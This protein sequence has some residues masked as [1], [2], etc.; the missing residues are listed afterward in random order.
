MPDIT[1]IGI[2]SLKELFLHLKKELVIAPA[3]SEP[4]ESAPSHLKTKHPNLDDVIGQEQAKRALVI[5]AAGRHNILLKGSPGTGKTML[6]QALLN[7]LP[8][9][10]PAERLA[11]TTSRVAIVGGG[12]KPQPGEISLAHLGVL[13]LDELPEYPRST[14]ESLRQPL[15]D[16]QISVSRAQGKLLYPADI[17]LVATMNPCPCGYFGDASKECSCT[18]NQI[19]AY[20]KRL[21]GPL[22]DRIDLS[23][24]VP[25]VPQ[26]S[27]LQHNSLQSTQQKNAYDKLT[28]AI[29]RQHNRFNSSAKYNANLTSHEIRQQLNLP[30]SCKQLLAAATEK[31]QLSTRAYFRVVR[32]AR[33]IA[34]LEDSNEINDSHIAEALQYR[35]N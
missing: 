22:L 23:V 26:S 15:E 7:L 34:D 28:K 19:A 6:A 1:V 16:R 14:L 21:S 11:H 27:L 4:A 12:V 24:T 17:M 13:F 33:T 25:R 10:S 32:I 3:E 20:Q 2:S 35:S 31:L 30:E 5:A 29:D 18:Q 9:P 8:P